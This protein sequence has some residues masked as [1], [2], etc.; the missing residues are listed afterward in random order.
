MACSGLK[1]N[2]KKVDQRLLNKHHSVRVVEFAENILNFI[3]R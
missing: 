2:E 1:Q 3:K